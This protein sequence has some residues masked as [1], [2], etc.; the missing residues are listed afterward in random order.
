MWKHVLPCVRLATRLI[1]WIVKITCPNTK[2]TCPISIKTKDTIRFSLLILHNIMWKIRKV[3]SCLDFEI[4]VFI[5]HE[6]FEQF[7]N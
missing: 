5:I 3:R 1:S 2:L 6:L 7:L 4:Q